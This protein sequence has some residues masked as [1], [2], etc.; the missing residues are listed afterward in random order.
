[1]AA[2]YHFLT[3]WLLGGP[4]EPIWEAI[5]DQKAW[6][7]WWR[8]VEDV[9]ELEPGDEDGVGSHSRLTWRSKLPYTLAF[10]ARTRRVERPRLIEVEADGELIGRGRWRLFEQDGVTV[11]LY[12]WNVTTG[13]RWMNSLAPAL[14]PVFEWNHNWVMRNGGTGISALLG[15]PLL[16]S[17]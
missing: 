2:Q 8:G 3:T 6:P 14:R 16:A 17:D 7:R 10:E 15:V 11:V 4:R 1:M 5:F 13:K 9:V 12:E